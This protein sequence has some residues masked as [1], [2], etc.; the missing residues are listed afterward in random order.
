VIRAVGSSAFFWLVIVAFAA[1]GTLIALSMSLSIYDEHWHVGIIR[2]YADQFG[3][4]LPN[5]DAT[6]TLGDVEYTGSF[7]YH[8]LMS[9]PYRAFEAMFGDTFTTLALTRLVG[10]AMVTGGLVVWRHTL[11]QVIASRAIVNVVI[12][13]MAAIPLMSFVAA[14]VNY[15]NLLFL[16]V[17]GY[18][19]WQV[20][21]AKNDGRKLTDWVWLAMFGMLASITKF[22]FVP[23]FAVLAVYT[24]VR[25]LGSLIRAIRSGDEPVRWRQLIVPGAI[26]VV[27]TVM[28]VDRYVRNVVMFGSVDPNCDLVASHDYCM[29]YGVYSRNEGFEANAGDPLSPSIG[30]ALTTFFDGWLPGVTGTLSWIGVRTTDGAVLDTFGGSLTRDLLFITTVLVVALALVLGR[31]LPERYRWPIWLSLGVHTAALFYLNYS[32]LLKYGL[33]YAYSSRYFFPYLPALIVLAVAG[34]AAALVK[35]DPRNGRVVAVVLFGIALVWMTQGA[36]PITYL[37]AVE[38]TWLHPD[39]PIQE[40]VMWL[41]KAGDRLMVLGH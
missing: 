18:L 7:L 30:G 35:L 19:Y 12:G 4:R 23:V 1:S 24:F 2:A 11:R 38:T 36:G 15:D 25:Y 41:A 33:L 5:G 17:A 40:L 22:T 10:V 37:A 39:S 21:L 31:A 3:P 14:T 20:R 26:F 34:L 32:N 6:L 9:Y 27:A 8:W 16:L 28:A 29:T 13:F